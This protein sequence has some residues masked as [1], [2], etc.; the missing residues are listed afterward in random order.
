MILILKILNK[1]YKQ[2]FQ[3]FENLNMIENNMEPLCSIDP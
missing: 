3:Y 1:F 2:K